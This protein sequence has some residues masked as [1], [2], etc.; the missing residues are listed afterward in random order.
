MFF[1]SPDFKQ[2]RGFYIL[3]IILSNKLKFNFIECYNIYGQP[4]VGKT[5]LAK[6]IGYY[7]RANNMFKDGVYY[8]GLKDLKKNENDNNLK[9][10]MARFFGEAFSYKM[11]Y[12]FKNKDMLLI[13][14]DF[15]ELFKGDI[16]LSDHIF[17]NL[18]D[19]KIPYIAITKNPYSQ[20]KKN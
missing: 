3:F 7:L 8:F 12:F 5:M 2:T 13:F 10:L 1:L 15:E 20:W 17:E 14:D 9:N 19:N 16:Q 11:M 18:Q 6:K 4:G